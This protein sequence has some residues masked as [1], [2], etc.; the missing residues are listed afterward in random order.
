MFRILTTLTLSLILILAS[1]TRNEKP[2]RL[3]DANVLYKCQQSIDECIIFDHFPPLQASRNYVYPHIAV[4]EAL[5]PFYPG[6]RS[7]HGQ[8]ND[9]PQITRPDTALGY[10]LDAII[11]AAFQ[12]TG[13]ALVYSRYLDTFR[14]KTLAELEN[15]V[16]AKSL[17]RSVEYGESVADAILTW[18]GK[19]NFR[20]TRNA[21]QHNPATSPTSWQPTTP[22]FERGVEPHW[23]TLRPMLLT[24]D[25]FPSLEA[26]MA[27]DLSATSPFMRSAMEV[28]EIQKNL[29]SQQITIAWYW[30]DNPV[31]V[32]HFGHATIK[33]FK[34]APPGH[35][36]GIT[37]YATRKRG[38][39]L[40]ET[41]E[42]F[43]RVSISAFDALIACWKE[44]Y[45][46]DYIRP[47]TVLRR[48]VINSFTP[49]IQTPPFPEYPSGHA[50]ISA[51]NSR[52]LNELFG[53]YTFTDSTMLQFGIPPRTFNG[54]IEAADEAAM[55]RLYG[56]IHFRE[57]NEA[58]KK[59]G[60][61]I[62]AIHSRSLVTREK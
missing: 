21:P 23:G 40:M 42:A 32:T 47:E 37:Q 29:D 58:G 7:L 35:W 46:W 59:L 17:Q 10:N 57:G 61:S 56:G 31:T 13:T 60:A 25:N 3:V 39:D 4:Y 27:F 8:L 49:L 14:M 6:Y 51:S 5:V 11:V 55:S 1:C 48:H 62:H 20:E 28:F 38:T 9:F 26:P 34:L 24:N 15:I 33:T 16:D 30:D 41:S 12:K 18:A 19:D 53:A 52:V 54:F 44:K 2:P 36:M 22:D 43:L 50:T 45:R